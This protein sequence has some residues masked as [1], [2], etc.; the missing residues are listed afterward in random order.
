MIIFS[1]HFKDLISLSPGIYFAYVVSRQHNCFF[2]LVAFNIFF[3]FVMFHSLRC[4]KVWIY[5]YLPCL[6]LSI[7]DKDSLF[8]LNGWSYYLLKYS[9]SFP[10]F[11]S[12]GTLVRCVLRIQFVLYVNCSLRFRYVSLGE[13]T[14]QY[15][16]H[17]Y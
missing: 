12:P 10:S 11:S 5:Y 2:S 7:Y 16:L 1:L 3:S 15:I 8:F 4:V 9:L 6:V 14:P 17:I 13:R